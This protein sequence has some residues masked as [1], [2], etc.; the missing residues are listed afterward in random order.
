M[1]SL[2]RVG[3]QARWLLDKLGRKGTG[4]G[5]VAFGETEIGAEGELMA[6]PVDVG[7]VFL[8]PGDPEDYRVPSELGD[9]E[10]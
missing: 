1:W 5:D 3:L 4:C 7:V 10:L 9:A 2:L 6:G 8:Q